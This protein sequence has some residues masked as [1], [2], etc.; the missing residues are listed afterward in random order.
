MLP[1]W[2]GVVIAVS[3]AII[4]LAALVAAAAITTT[5]LGMRAWLHTLRTYAGPALED[6]RHLIGTIRIEVD[7]LAETSRDL[8]G[9]IVRA[10]DAAETRLAQVNALL[11][12]V[13]GSF[14]STA[15]GA[16][17]T[18]RLLLPTIRA[19]LRNIKLPWGRRLKSGRKASERKKR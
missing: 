5:A 17:A 6:A 9:R 1:T 4:A 2:V 10:A 11:G 13:Q 8:R 15:R 7:A 19:L 14:E 16:V 18:V 12:G 3:L